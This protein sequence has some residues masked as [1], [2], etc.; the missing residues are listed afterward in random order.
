MRKSGV[1]ATR[2]YLEILGVTIWRTAKLL[3]SF[4]P[5]REATFIGSDDGARRAGRGMLKR[6]VLNRGV[7]N[8]G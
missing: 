4:L 8:P 1:L 6:G 7:L 3:S 2:S 5:H